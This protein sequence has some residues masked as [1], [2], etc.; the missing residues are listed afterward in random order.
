[1]FVYSFGIDSG[2][3][4]CG[5]CA[6]RKA[7]IPRVDDY[8]LFKV[9]ISCHRELDTQRKYRVDVFEEMNTSTAGGSSTSCK[10]ADD[11]V[12]VIVGSAGVT[13]DDRE[14]VVFAVEDER[15][16]SNAAASNER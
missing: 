10:A 14:P 16:V 7:R 1:M 4:V 9:C 12:K 15:G 8:K 6:S 2:K 3:C 5:S 13:A 11:E